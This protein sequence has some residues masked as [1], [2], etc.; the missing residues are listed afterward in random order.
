MF[1]RLSGS[2]QLIVQLLYRSGLRVNE[3]VRLRVKDVDFRQH[4][5]M[6]KAFKIGFLFCLKAFSSI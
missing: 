3:E 2:F 4:Q 5:M 6:S 1:V